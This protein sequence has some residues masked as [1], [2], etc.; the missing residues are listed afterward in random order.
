MNI[1]DINTIL[2]RND[3][4]NQIC[5][6]LRDFEKNKMILLEKEQSTY[7]DLLDVGKQHL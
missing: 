7:T 3:I 4:Y 1:P 6:F 2:S 5:E